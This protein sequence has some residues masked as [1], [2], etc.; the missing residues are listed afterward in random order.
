MRCRAQISAGSGPITIWRVVS[1]RGPPQGALL[2]VPIC[3]APRATG[4]KDRTRLSLNGCICRVGAITRR[5]SLRETQAVVSRQGAATS[6]RGPGTLRGPA[7]GRL[8]TA[9]GA[10][11][12]GVRPVGIIQAGERSCI[13]RCR[14]GG[15]G[16]SGVSQDFF[17]ALRRRGHSTTRGRGGGRSLGHG[18]TF[19]GIIVRVKTA[20]GAEACRWTGSRV[21]KGTAGNRAVS[22]SR[23]VPKVV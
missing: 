16:P 23:L 8:R 11:R 14:V 2:I 4:G 13:W 19:G 5:R 18:G 1:I 22:G 12:T 7:I 17:R 9:S 6:G 3:R 20:S 15:S 21:R 10:V